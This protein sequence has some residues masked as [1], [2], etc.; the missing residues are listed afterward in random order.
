MQWSLFGNTI[1]VLRKVPENP[2][3][4]TPIGWT[5]FTDIRTYIILYAPRKSAQGPVLILLHD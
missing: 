1:Q 4:A 2:S 3:N 5:I